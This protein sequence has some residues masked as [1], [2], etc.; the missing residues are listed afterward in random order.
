MIN[1]LWGILFLV[2]LLSCGTN[3]VTVEI[4][5][6]DGHKVRLDAHQLKPKSNQLVEAGSITFDDVEH[7][8]YSVNVIAKGH[9]ASKTVE[10]ESKPITGIQSYRLSFEIPAGANTPYEPQGT[11]LFASTP[12]TARNWDLFTIKPDGTELTQLTDTREFEQHPSWSPDGQKILFTRGSALTNMDIYVMNA[13]GSGINRLTEHP[14]RDERAVWSPDGSQIA[15]VSQRDGHLTIWLMDPQGG[16]KR[17][18]V[19]GREPAWS[20]DGRHIAFTSGQFEG[21]DEIYIIDID[22]SNMRRVTQHK[23]FDWFPKWSP[24]GKRLAFCSERFGGQEL[25]IAEAESGFQTRIT[26]AEHTFE[27]EPEWSPDGRALAYQGKM[28]ILENGELAVEEHLPGRWR[29]MGSFDIFIVPAVGFDWDESVERA[30]L[31]VN[32]TN[33]PD[34]DEWSPSWRA[35]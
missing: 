34:R 25:M 16:N 5:G 8:S 24:E 19:Q 31:P 2:T 15:F 18:L 21:N 30:V 32:L 10:I 7:G 27:V 13:D 23:R 28:T 4:E 33:T 3:E 20:P 26:V 1:A 14:E 12:I 35:F 29:P 17:K 22:G 6:G 11:I 9:V